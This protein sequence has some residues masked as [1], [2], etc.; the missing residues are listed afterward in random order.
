M[1]VHDILNGIDVV[2]CGVVRIAAAAFAADRCI[3]CAVR[4]Q[5]RFVAS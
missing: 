3:S 1:Q 5:R 4:A 2:D